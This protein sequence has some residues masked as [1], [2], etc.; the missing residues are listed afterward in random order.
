MADAAERCAQAVVQDRHKQTTMPVVLHR[1]QEKAAS[2]LLFQIS[3]V[4]YTYDKSG[5]LSL[6]SLYSPCEVSH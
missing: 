4:R 3:R 5:T 6:N 2:S 1:R